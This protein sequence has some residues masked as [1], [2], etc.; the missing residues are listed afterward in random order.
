MTVF[1]R[2]WQTQSKRK[3][4]HELTAMPLLNCFLSPNSKNN[5]SLRPQRDDFIPFIGGPQNTTDFFS[6]CGGYFKAA[7]GGRLP[8]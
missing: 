3:E 8:I 4:N 5:F 1:M 2:N 6:R 7:S